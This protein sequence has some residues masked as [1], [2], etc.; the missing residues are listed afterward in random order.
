[1]T[2]IRSAFA[3]LLLFAAACNSTTAPTPATAP[4]KINMKEARRMVG[5]E[6]NV[7]IDAEIYGEDLRQGSSIAIKYEITNQRST[8]ILIADLVAQ[9]NYDPDTRTVTIDVGSEI[10]GEEF[11]PRLI[12]IPSGE[13]RTF[14]TGANINIHMPSNSPWTPK[15]R[16]LQLRVNF[17]GDPAPFAMLVGIPERAVRDKK[18]ADD[19]FTKWVERNETVTTNALPMRW[20]DTH[21]S[22]MDDSVPA[23]RRRG[24]G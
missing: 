17:L 12:S 21:S 7:R 4:G 15:P 23:R 24:P 5:T 3:L 2:L 1:M 11:L 18:L 13:R 10:P 19:L 14:N 16:S 9:S 8:P 6:N 20:Q 22:G